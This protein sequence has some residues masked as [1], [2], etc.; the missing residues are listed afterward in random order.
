STYRTVLGEAKHLGGLRWIVVGLL[1]VVGVTFHYLFLLLIVA[2]DLY[3]LWLWGRT[4]QWRRLALLLAIQ[5]TAGLFLLLWLVN[6]PGPLDTLLEALAP[7]WT[8]QPTIWHKL[9]RVVKDWAVGDIR[10]LEAYGRS[11]PFGVFLLL[12]AALGVV[13][14]RWQQPEEKQG[15]T[16]G[17]NLRVLLLMVLFIPPLIGMAIIPIVIGRYFIGALFAFFLLLA[18]A[19]NA[20]W[21]WQR[22]IGTVAMVGVLAIFIYGLFYQYTTAKGN[23]GRTLRMTEGQV[24]PRDAIVLTHPHTWP[25]VSYYGSRPLD[26]YYYVPDVPYALPSDE[27]VARLQPIL[28]G[29]N[30]LVLGPAAPSH[31]EPAT[32][33]RALNQLAFPSAKEWYPNSIFVASY[34]TPRPMQEGAGIWSWGDIIGLSHWQHS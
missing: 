21:R 26:S 15:T 32:V 28:A 19:L 16:G 2:A 30:R 17:Y 24:G 7:E 5:G 27:I 10:N 29:H 22:L 23:F 13:V 25:Q 4:G 31:T 14:P 33:E 9:A 18:L 20:L 6:A 11:L 3:L 1:A 34:L 12:L 8:T